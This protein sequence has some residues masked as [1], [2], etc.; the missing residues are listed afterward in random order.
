MKIN[1]ETVS[2]DWE[3]C[4]NRV[5]GG[6][7][8]IDSGTIATRNEHINGQP[9]DHNKRLRISFAVLRTHMFSFRSLSESQM[10]AC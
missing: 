7:P 2:G 3:N 4:G 5:E 8:V 1:F 6:W 10:I 9:R